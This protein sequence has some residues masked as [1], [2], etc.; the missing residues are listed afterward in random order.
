M[1]SRNRSPAGIPGQIRGTCNPDPDSFVAKL[2]E[3]WIDKDTGY[4]ITIRAGIVKYFARI[5][6][7]LVWGFSKS[8][9]KKKYGPQCDPLSLTFIPA[10]VFDNKILL[11][12]NPRYLANLR[13]LPPVERE[14]LLN[15]NWLVRPVAGSYFKRHLFGIVD[16]VPAAI[17]ARCRFWDRAASELRAENDPDATVGLKLAWAEDGIFYIED[18]VRMFAGPHDVEKAMKN[19]AQQ[20]GVNCLVAYQQ[21]PGSAGVKEAQDTARA[22]AGFVV[23]YQTETGDKETRAKPVSSQVP[24][25]NI[26]LVRGPWNDHFLRV[27]ENFPVGRF[28]DEVDALSGAFNKLTSGR[29]ILI[30]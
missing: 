15:G 4:P 25:G 19:L 17:K 9:L 21:D 22:L 7:D 16:A 28:D 23:S 1:L 3:W 10:S 14:Q 20:D 27:L 5:H 30:G 26:K 6:D 11:A 24:A 13:N 18:V 12:Q 29:E 8:E 2:I